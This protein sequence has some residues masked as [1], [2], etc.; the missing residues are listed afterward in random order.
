MKSSAAENTHVAAVH[1]RRK[2][3]VSSLTRI[4]SAEFC[5]SWLSNVLNNVLRNSANKQTN[6]QNNADEMS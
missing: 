1:W 5:E 3:M 4:S 6:K 2:L